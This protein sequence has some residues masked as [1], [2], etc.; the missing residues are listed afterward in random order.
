MRLSNGMMFRLLVLGL[1]IAVSV[2]PAFA[3]Q[4]GKDTKTAKEIKT[5]QA[6]KAEKTVKQ[7][8]IETKEASKGNIAVVNGVAISREDFDR[9]IVGVQEQAASRG[10]KIEDA[11]LDEIKKRVLE[12]L[13]D[14]ELLYQES[15]KMGIK[16]ED[17]MVDEQ[18]TKLK[19]Q[20][21][22]NEDFNK[23]LLKV[24]LTEASLKSQI[25]QIMMIQQFIDREFVQK[26]TVSEE[27]LKAFFEAHLKARIEQ[28]LKQEKIQ[29]EVT[30]YIEKLKEKAKVERNLP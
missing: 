29:A 5:Q 2:T 30:S 11:Q 20:Y 18:Y 9:E 17:S 26:I 25:K 4:A 10:E 14:G 7:E 15:Q 16:V 21:P 12:K 28:N 6:V 22:N 13:I 8:K 24:K 19:D 1:C 27:E 3:E 23:E